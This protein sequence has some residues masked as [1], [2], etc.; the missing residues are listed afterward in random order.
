MDALIRVS[1]LIFGP[2]EG[3]I[4]RCLADKMGAWVAVSELCRAAYGRPENF[5]A[6]AGHSVKSMLSRM[7]VKLARLG[8]AITGKRRLGYML[9]P[10]KPERT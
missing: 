5:P 1:P 8:W 10:C 7:R 2:T 6:F 4:L 3:V 9:H